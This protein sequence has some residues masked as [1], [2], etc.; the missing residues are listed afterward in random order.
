MAIASPKKPKNKKNGTPP[1]ARRGWRAL[2]GGPSFFSNL[3]TTVLIFLLL[4]SIYWLV[5]GLAKPAVDV[6]LS[7]VAA[8]VAEG[9][10]RSITVNGDSLGL[11]YTDE[12]TKVSRKDPSAGLPETLATYG[13]T[14][15]ELSKVSITIRGQSGF[16]FW[17]LTLA[18]ILLPL[19]FVAAFF[20]II[21]RQVRGAGMQ[22]FSFG[23][24]KAR[25]IDP[26]DSSPRVTFADIAGAREAKEE[27]LEIV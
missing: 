6:P 5:E 23:Q 18:P 4:M 19:L 26:A 13:V 14:P 11:V 27:L 17:F 7:V 10:I 8:D 2:F 25:V 16:Q 24:S 1:P 12:S 3:I 21:S 20:W 9:K 22:A 15:E